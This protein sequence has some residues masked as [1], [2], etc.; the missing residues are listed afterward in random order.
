ME[1]IKL[2]NIKE[3]ILSENKGLANVLRQRLTENG[4]LFLNVMSSPGSGKTS[5]IVKTIEALKERY[6]IAV[7]E[8]DIDS[9][10]DAKTIADLGVKTMQMHTGGFCHVDANMVEKTVE[11]LLPDKIDLLILENVG[12]LVCP[13]ETDTGAHKN[14]AILSLP[15]GDDKPL[16]YPLMFSVCDILVINKLDYQSI[17]DF[18]MEFVTDKVKALNPKTEIM[19]LSCKTSFGIDKWVDWLE[20]E[21]NSMRH[22]LK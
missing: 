14:V 1:E 20:N 7:I 10:V 22:Q 8:A 11:S 4:T 15:E 18:N 21:I 13:A 16:K 2:I 12:N 6:T 3:E 19:P 5:L 17:T 9:M